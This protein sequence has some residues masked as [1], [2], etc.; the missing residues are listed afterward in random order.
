MG[1]KSV[2]DH[3]QIL[4]AVHVTD[5]GICIGSPYISDLIVI[6]LDGVLKKRHR[7]GTNAELDRYMAE[8]DADPEKLK[9]LVARPDT[10]TDAL[11]VYT[12]D[13]GEIIEAKCEEY[14]WP[15]VTHEGRMMYENTFFKSKADAVKHAKADAACGV[16]WRGEA[17][18][19]AEQKLAEQKAELARCE[20]ELAKLNAD[21]PE[22]E[23]ALS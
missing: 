21:Y 23:L 17:V 5:A 22:P 15:N 18:V 10:F 9:E 20:A 14:G 16:K 4:H 6:G 13:G 1:F 12:W 2:K 7:S 8:F 3:Y 11:P 19:E